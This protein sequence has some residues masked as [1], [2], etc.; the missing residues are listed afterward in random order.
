MHVLHPVVLLGLP[1]WLI[2]GTFKLRKRS[3]LSF[4][5]QYVVNLAYGHEETR[6][7]FYFVLEIR[8]L[9]SRQP[10][11]AEGRAQR[12]SMSYASLGAILAVSYLMLFAC[13]ASQAATLDGSE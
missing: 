8:R 6:I 13:L 9:S 10:N 5:L 7:D 3:C 4:W 11:D 2:M 1:N 12:G